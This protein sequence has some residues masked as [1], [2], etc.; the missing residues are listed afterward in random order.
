MV[1][2]F[3]CEDIEQAQQIRNYDGFELIKCAKFYAFHT[4]K[5]RVL[6]I[7]DINSVEK[8]H[9]YP[10]K[11]YGKSKKAG[12]VQKTL[13][14]LCQKF[15]IAKPKN[16]KTALVQVFSN[17]IIIMY[18]YDFYDYFVHLDHSIIHMCF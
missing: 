17:N 18:C 8:L 15:S 1:C 13:A 5:Q 14:S 6:E 11:E 10:N 2:K 9:E 4:T 7:L 3:L 12:P 16:D